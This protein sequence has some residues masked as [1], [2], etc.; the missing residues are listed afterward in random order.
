MG[1]IA[2]FLGTGEPSSAQLAT[3]I[4]EREAAIATKNEAIERYRADVPAAAIRGDYLPEHTMVALTRELDADR[5]ILDDLRDAHS[6]ALQRER[7]A[8]REKDFAVAEDD[9]RAL[10]AVGKEG[11]DLIALIADWH[12]RVLA[13]AAKFRQS[14]S[15]VEPSRLVWNPAR[16]PENLARTIEL[17]LYISSDGAIA[18]PSGVAESPFQLAKEPRATVLGSI[19]EYIAIAL[20]GRQPNGVNPAAT[21]ITDIQPAMTAAVAATED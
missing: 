15:V 8:Q 17:D 19:R 2:K 10:E 4:D 14:A 1:W 6:Q 3:V 12:R 9:A 21:G 18:P 11:A 16:F 7:A 13:A 20:Q 5:W